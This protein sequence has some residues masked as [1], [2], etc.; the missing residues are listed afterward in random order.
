MLYISPLLV[1][2]QLVKGSRKYVRQGD[3]CLFYSEQATNK[4][5]NASTIVFRL[6]LSLNC[7]KQTIFFPPN[8]LRGALQRLNVK[9]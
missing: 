2:R 5:S 7:T 9:S 1:H 3:F 8:Y 6:S 4:S